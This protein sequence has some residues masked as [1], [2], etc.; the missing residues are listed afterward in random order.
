MHLPNEILLSILGSL[1]RSDL[2]S[3]RL[4][5]QAWCVS[6]SIFLFEEIHVS[7]AKDDLEIFEAIA[8]NPLL[9]TCVRHLRY[10][11]TAFIHRLSR[12]QYVRKLYCQSPYVLESDR[13]PWKTSDP[14]VN[15][16]VD[17]VI[18]GR[19]PM[20]RAIQKFK[21]H[22]FI[23]Q[24]HENYKKQASFQHAILESG[25]FMKRLMKGLEKLAS[26]RSVTIEASWHHPRN[27]EDYRTGSYLARHWH[28]FHCSPEGWQWGKRH[29]FD[30][31]RDLRAPDGSES[32]QIMTSAL[33]QAHRQISS[34]EISSGNHGSRGLPPSLFAGTQMTRG[35]VKD[36]KMAID[37]L[38]RLEE[39][40]LRFAS[41]EEEPEEG[42]STPELFPNVA[43]L[44]SLLSSM[45]YLK[46]LELRL[47]D[48]L[49]EPPTLY[50]VNQIL[51]SGKTWRTLQSLILVDLSTTA[52]ELLHVVLYGAPNLRHLGIGGIDLSEGSWEAFFE[53]L[54]YSRHLWSLRLEFDTYLF[55]HDGADFWTDDYRESLYDDLEE[56]VVYGGR[57]PCLRDDQPD[58]A[59]ADYL[60]EFD[61]IVRKCLIQHNQLNTSENPG[62]NGMSLSVC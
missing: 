19:F 15:E 59:A 44:A 32:F 57:H 24:G 5:S 3:A 17:T 39:C 35:N 22:R 6:A 29:Y 18:L 60:S 56:Y 4:V 52:R 54:A 47:P 10:D 34:F 41:H 43:G 27:L 38:S 40:I 14:E 25:Q 28:R 11:A 36:S 61:P 55:H 42:E 8:Q 21:N 20:G 31:R 58:G 9:S 46:H 2:K 30:N 12:Q 16:W 53:A 50:A 1:Y 48:D 26:L 13:P 51:P 37:A 62:L 33:A 23:Q 45:D 49:C 7:S